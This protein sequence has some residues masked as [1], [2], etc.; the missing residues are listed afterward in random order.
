MLIKPLTSLSDEVDDIIQMSR[1][2][3]ATIYPPESIYQDDPHNLING[4]MYFIGAFKGENLCGIGGVK[5]MHEDCDFGEIKNLFVNPV[6]RGQGVSKKIMRALEQY[7][8]D[9]KICLCR[10]ETG[11]NQPESLGLYRAMGYRVRDAFGA[12]RNDPLS[13]FMEKVIG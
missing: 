11:V 10:L 9:K 7:L 3:Q 13:I 5:I 4:S 1:Q 12:Y 8:I 6:Y 2:Y